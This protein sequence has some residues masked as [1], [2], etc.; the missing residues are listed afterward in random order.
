MLP[1]LLLQMWDRSML[2]HS[3]LLLLH[4]IVSQLESSALEQITTSWRCSWSPAL[5]LPSLCE[6]LQAWR[7][8]PLKVLHAVLKFLRADGHGRTLPAVIIKCTYEVL[9]KRRGHVTEEVPKP[10]TPVSIVRAY[11]PVIESFG[12]ETDLRCTT[13][14]QAFCLSTFDHWQ[15]EC[16]PPWR[17]TLL[18]PCNVSLVLNPLT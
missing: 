5:P 14:G 6:C 9:G 3:S 11:L 8:Q 2:Q 15:V 18:L 13:Q 10:G 17:S 12:F 4:V 1:S 7:L 16:W